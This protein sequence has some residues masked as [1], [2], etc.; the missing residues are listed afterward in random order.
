MRPSHEEDSC[1]PGSPRRLFPAQ[2]SLTPH[3]LWLSLEPQD[4]REYLAAA[5]Q[6]ILP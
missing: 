4:I 6:V 2:C 3:N 5:Q 1:R